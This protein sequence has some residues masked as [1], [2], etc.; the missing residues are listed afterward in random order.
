MNLNSGAPAPLDTDII[1]APRRPRLWLR[2]ALEFLAGAS[3]A[4]SALAATEFANRVCATDRELA[5]TVDSTKSH[6]SG[7]EFVLAFALGRWGSIEAA[8]VESVK[9]VVRELAAV[10]TEAELKSVTIVTEGRE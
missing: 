9:P 2:V 8:R 10:F 6:A 1:T 4:R 3:P 5:L 7:G